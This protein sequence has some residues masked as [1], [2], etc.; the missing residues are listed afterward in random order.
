MN[1]VVVDDHRLPIQESLAGD[2]FERH[3]VMAKLRV[4]EARDSRLTQS[5]FVLVLD[6]ENRPV[7]LGDQGKIVE[8]SGDLLLERTWP[9]QEVCHLKEGFQ[10]AVPVKQ[11]TFYSPV[12]LLQML[13]LRV[14]P[15]EHLQVV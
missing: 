1:G 11:G 8:H 6:Q 5:L 7:R 10:L 4:A 14:A 12:V 2:A 9:A 13:Q 15:P 3:Q